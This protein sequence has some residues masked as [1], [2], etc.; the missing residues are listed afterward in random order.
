[1]PCQHDHE[2]SDEE[3]R[4]LRRD[5]TGT[6]PIRRK[7][8][9][10]AQKRFKALR[11]ITQRVIVELDALGLRGLTIDNMNFAAIYGA[12]AN[13]LAV[14][15]DSLPEKGR[16]FGAW[17][18]EAGVKMITG[19][20]WS[21]PFVEA[22][23]LKGMKDAGTRVKR[24]DKI[25]PEGT[26]ADR[27]I[28]AHMLMLIS[29]RARDSIRNVVDTMNNQMT[30]L[31][32][33]DLTEQ[34]TPE[35]IARDMVGRIDAIGINRARLVASCETSSSYNEAAIGVYD[36]AGVIKV[37]VIPEFIPGR[38]LN[39]VH[40]AKKSEEEKAPKPDYG[41][42]IYKRGEKK[43]E[44]KATK[45]WPRGRWPLVAWATAGDDFVCPECEALEDQVFTL[46]T[47][48]GMFPLHP[49]C[50]CALYPLEEVDEEE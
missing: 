25:P 42:G 27:A 30:Q 45:N 19:E 50:R 1:M 44:P 13:S 36:E 16:V 22:A 35:E 24:I 38:G 34:R 7:F 31:L 41:P 4:L 11:A 39:K 40:D 28:H 6:A 3:A 32:A 47:A 10:E 46:Q 14:V 37:G 48:R 9:S 5:P 8:D 49:N 12:K 29:N 17:L 18:R 20:D 43:G 21:S 26:L 15:A 33:R 2:F 23:Y